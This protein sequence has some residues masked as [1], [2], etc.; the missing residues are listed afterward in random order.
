MESDEN[1]PPNLRGHCI[2]IFEDLI[3]KE[4]MGIKP[5]LYKDHSF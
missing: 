4:V 5:V 3:L 2:T 1:Q